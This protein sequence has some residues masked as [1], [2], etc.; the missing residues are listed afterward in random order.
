MFNV[1]A[2]NVINSKMKIYEKLNSNLE[3]KKAIK[4]VPDNYLTLNKKKINHNTKI[5]VVNLETLK[6]RSITIKELYNFYPDYIN[7]IIYVN[8]KPYVKLE[9]LENKL[10]LYNNS[11]NKVVIECKKRDKEVYDIV[12]S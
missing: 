11:N 1:I 3:V 9:Y 10:I 2:N 8:D 5:K 6:V 7:Y 4:K 12:L